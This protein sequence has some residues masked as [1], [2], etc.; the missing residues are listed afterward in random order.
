MTK[1]HIKLKSSAGMPRVGATAYQA[2]DLAHPDLR[3]WQPFAG[4]ADADFIPE[5]G[6]IIA[7]SRDLTRNHGVADAARQTLHDN[8]VGCGLRLSAKPNWKVLK[9]NREWAEVLGNDIEAW[10]TTW[11]GTVACDAG[12]SLVGDGLTSQIFNSA[13]LNGAGLALPLWMPERGFRFATCLQVIEADRLSNP[14]D[15][16]NSTTLRGGIEIN[17]YGKPLAYQ[18]RHA[19]PGDG[20]FAAGADMM[21][22]TRI[23]ATTGWGRARVIHVHDKER[24]GSSH[25]KPSLTSVMRQFKVLGDLTNAELK[26]AVVNAMV[27]MFVESSL[28]QE[29]IV[30]LLQS[31]PDAMKRYQDGLANRESASIDFMGG[32]IIPVKLGEKISSYKSER[33]NTNFDPFVTSLFR[34]IAAGLHIP[35]ELLLKDF[36][37]TNYSSARAAL[38]EA[39]RFF[40]GRRKW[41]ATYWLAPVYR[42]FLEELVSLKLVD[43]ELD[44][45]Y[46]NWEAYTRCLWIGDGRGYVDPLKEQQASRGRM[47]DGTSTLEIE[48]A[49]QGL[50]WEEIQEQIAVELKFRADL[51]VQ[52]GIKFPTRTT[53]PQAPADPTEDAPP[54]GRDSNYTDKSPAAAGLSA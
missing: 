33:P 7:R 51:E 14:F 42:L 4:S 28:D 8:I 26:A 53:T 17:A 25:G 15:Q 27:A 18:I 19:H 54:P 38:N 35:Y 2:A 44:D 37:K 36:S 5:Q 46:A 22:W 1:P 9:R 31:N 49:E 16:P 20:W 3:R 11:W 52:Y 48:C 39:W 10:W 41:I 6:R 50:D 13:F 43:I 12:E 45:F 47:E 21:Q 30:E 23:P 40:R 32:R 29:A 34:H 24:A